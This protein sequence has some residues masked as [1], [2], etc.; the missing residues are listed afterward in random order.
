MGLL[1]VGALR[2]V[3]ALFTPAYAG[4]AKVSARGIFSDTV[5][6]GVVRLLGRSRTD[7]GHSAADICVASSLLHT[8]N[9]AAVDGI[10][11]EDGVHGIDL[12]GAA[13]RFVRAAA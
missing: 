13:A 5:G 2:N 4:V 12:A 8:V 3:N 9:G 11:A 6:A 10:G 1:R 7:G